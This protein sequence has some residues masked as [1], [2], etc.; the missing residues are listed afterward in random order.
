MAK[1]GENIYK[2]K[3]GRYEGRYIKAYS[4]NGKAQYG[5]IYGKT[6]AYVSE[7]LA[8][9]KAACEHNEKTVSCSISLAKWTKIWLSKQNLIKES[10][11]KIYSSYADKHII[12]DLGKYELQCLT[13][14]HIQNFVNL[15]SKELSAK[16]VRSIFSLLRSILKEAYDNN[17]ISDV[18]S[19]INLPKYK[20]REVKILSKKEQ[21]LLERAVEKSS[22]ANDIGILIC[23]YTGLRIGELCALTWDNIDLNNGILSVKQ[24][25]Y[26]VK[27]NDG[28]SKTKIVITT[29]KSEASIRNI[30][31]PKFLL[32]KLCERKQEHG[33][34]INNNG[35]PIE[36]AV[37]SRT[38]NR[39]LKQIG[40]QHTKFHALRH[41]FA[42]RALEIGMDVKTLSEILGHTS[43]SI[44]LNF[45]SHS[46]FEHK[47]QEMEKLGE[48]YKPSI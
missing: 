8:R 10:T 14:T 47:K 33:F 30:P 18:F 3:D 41:T 20:V 37:Y 23:L 34:V 2:R 39:L 5:Y 25:I 36:T 22:A 12:A 6:Y 26:R 7:T 15:K 17:L 16:T 21:E 38:Y 28:P 32:K 11:Y 46:L 31:I 42:T 44:T 9:F 45:Y 13:R 40:I 19:N 27:N 43:P 35:K 48:L 4:D 24:T 1:K 29:P